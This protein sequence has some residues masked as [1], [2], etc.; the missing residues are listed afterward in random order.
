MDISHPL[1]IPIFSVIAGLIILV[2]P[3]I[4]NY[5]IALYLLFVGIIGI[6]QFFSDAS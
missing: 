2:F 3:R 1:L 5:A 6:L 4:L